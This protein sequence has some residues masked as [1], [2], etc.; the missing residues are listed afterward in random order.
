[1][2]EHEIDLIAALVEGRLEDETEA[3]ALITSSPEM[4]QEYQAQKLAYEALAGAGMVRMTESE[5]SA[6]HRDI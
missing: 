5:R 3:R 2:R 4:R 6:L 1:M